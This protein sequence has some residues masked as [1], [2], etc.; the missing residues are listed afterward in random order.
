MY[1][2]QPLFADVDTFLRNQGFTL[3]DIQIPL[4]RKFR[5]AGSQSKGQVLWA[6][7]IYFKDLCAKRDGLPKDMDLQK[8]L[9][10]VALA[11]L[12]GFPDYSLSVYV[13]PPK[14]RHHHI[15]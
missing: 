3:F 9:K 13:S 6:H 4:G 10:T 8:A 14:N 12:H 15:P 11:E 7:T 2:N 5:K 1:Q